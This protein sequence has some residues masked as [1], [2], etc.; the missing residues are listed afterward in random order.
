[1]NVADVAGDLVTLFTADGLAAPLSTSTTVVEKYWRTEP[2]SG[3]IA[4]L[5]DPAGVDYEMVAV[6]DV[7]NDIGKILVY[8][9][10]QYHERATE[11]DLAW[12]MEEQIVSILR[13]NRDLRSEGQSGARRGE[14]SETSR[15]WLQREADQSGRQWY[16]IA[17]QL[18]YDMER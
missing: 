11:P 6:P 12:D 15:G 3:G 8:L 14:M 7:A 17:M 5:V 4:V 16:W 2:Y 18:T 9:T 10:I 13:G 1:M